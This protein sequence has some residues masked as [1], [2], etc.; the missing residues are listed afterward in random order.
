VSGTYFLTSETFY[1]GASPTPAT[2]QQTVVVDT[3]AGTLVFVD[4]QAGDTSYLAATY[5]TT[6]TSLLLTATC[7]TGPDGGI[8]E[9]PGGTPKAG[10]TYTA[11]GTT[12]TIFSGTTAGDSMSVYTKQ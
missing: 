4:T 2:D 9:V 1:P 12:V 5:T 11:T 7:G 8:L 3:T 6:G 10:N